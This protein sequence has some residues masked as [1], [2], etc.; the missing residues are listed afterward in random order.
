MQENERVENAKN[1]DV[2][3]LLEWLNMQSG[4]MV[5]F[6]FQY[7]LSIAEANEVT[8]DTYIAIRDDLSLLDETN[9]LLL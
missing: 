9:P 2:A 4:K 1:G 8:L 5:R 3:H 6:A 7:G